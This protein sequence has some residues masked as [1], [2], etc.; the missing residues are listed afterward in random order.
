MMS[1]HE[2]QGVIP[3][4]QHALQQHPDARIISM[5]ARGAVIKPTT[6]YGFKYMYDRAKELVGELEQQTVARKHQ[7]WNWPRTGIG[8]HYFY[9]HLL[10]HILKYKPQ[11]GKEIFTKLFTN[12]THEGIFGFLDEKSTPSLGTRNVRRSS[13][14]EIFMGCGSFFLR[15]L[16]HSTGALG[17][18]GDGTHCDGIAGNS[19][20]IRPAY[21]LGYSG[22]YAVF[23]RHTARCTG[24]LRSC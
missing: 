8:R 3:M 13:H 16:A 21:F 6:G 12:R 17:A 22:L 9:D 7:F 19:A 20:A 14:H 2:E 24:R 18:D 4:T 23:N 10:L 11:W 5:G 1:I 15:L